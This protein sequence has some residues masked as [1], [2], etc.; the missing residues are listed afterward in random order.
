[1]HIQI[2]ATRYKFPLV[3][4]EQTVGLFP[5]PID[6]RLYLT[7]L[8]FSLDDGGVPSQVS[9]AGYHPTIIAQYALVQWNQY[10]ASKNESCR[11]EFLIQAYRLIEHEVRIAKDAGGWPISSQRPDSNF[12]GSWLSALTQGNALSVLVRAY[13]LTQDEVFLASA[14]RVALTFERDILDGGVIAPIGRDGIFFEEVAVYPAAHTLNGCIF[15][16]FGLYDYLALTGNAAIREIIESSLS[17][18]HVLLDEF[19]T[20]FWI[21]ADL[22][23]RR[24]VSSSQLL[25][26][27]ELLSALAAISACEHCLKLSLRWQ[28]YHRQPLTRL[29]YYIASRKVSHSCVFWNRIRSRL[30]SLPRISYPLRVCV[31]ITAFPVAGG[32]RTVLAGVAQAMMGKW[33]V[34]HLTQYVGPNRGNFTIHRFG[35][36]KMSPWQFPMVWPYFFA[37]LRKLIQ[38]LRYKEG[39]HV[40]LP[41]D[42]VFTGAFAAIA[43]KLAGVRVVCI[44]HGNLTLLDSRMYRDE[45]LQALSNEHWIKRIC[46]NL[47]YFGYWPSLRLLAWISARL[48]DHFLIPGVEGDGVEDVCKQLKILPI[49][50]TRFANMIEIERHVILNASLRAETREKYGI[51]ANA[52]VIAIICRLAPEKGLEIALAAIC[53]ALSRL[54]PDIAKRVRVIIAGNGPMRKQLEEEIHL[55]GLSQTCLLWGEASSEEV[56]TIL[57]LSDI[58]LFTS[59]RAAGYPL[60]VLEAM[61]SGCAVIASTESLANQEMLAEGRGLIL[62]VGD[63]EGTSRAI[64][65]L[66][67]DPELCGQIGSLARKYVSTQHSVDNLRRSLLRVTSWSS[68]DKLL[69]TGMETEGS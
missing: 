58:F 27:A 63:V 23:H 20:G 60:S 67:N 61:A 15:A 52:V 42:G 16:L 38:L 17:T 53:R 45:L 65:R 68:L 46:A 28:Q 48:A 49:R 64:V 4:S 1:M 31:P 30:F 54:S 36:A 32:M 18:M 69:S 37:G 7:L 40:I 24:L 22:L 11:T 51:A 35:T 33:Q 8:Q 25:L 66:V 6:M 56:I 21:C 39:Y 2:A 5:Y 26:H 43:G 14:R 44:D 19:D 13:Q 59:W 47:L 34:E 62:P 9:L 12:E 10:L 3:N 29:R 55:Q 41:Q 57:S 50:I